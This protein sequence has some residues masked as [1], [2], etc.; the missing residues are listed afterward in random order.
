MIKECRKVM[1]QLLGSMLPCAADGFNMLVES[2]LW[3][4][5]TDVICKVYVIFSRQILAP[6]NLKKLC[7]KNY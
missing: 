1:E 7:Y 6:I 4:I 5:E 3:A 2:S